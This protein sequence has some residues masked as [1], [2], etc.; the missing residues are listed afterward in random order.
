MFAMPKIIATVIIWMMLYFGLHAQVLP[1]EIDRQKAA[2]SVASNDTARLNILVQLS[3]G[4]RFSNI[5]SALHYTEQAIKIAKK[6]NS[7]S[8]QAQMLSLKG[9]TLLESGRLP[10]S[11]QYQFEALN[12]GEEIKDTSA[13]AF[14]LNRIGNVYMELG[15][16]AKANDYYFLSESQFRSIRDT[17][18]MHNELSNIGNI[19]ALMNKPDSALYYQHIVY[20][21]SKITDDRNK[22]TRAEIMFRMGNAYQLNNDYSKA[23]SF[24]KQGIV[25][26]TIDNDLRNLS[27]TNLSIADL[28]LKLKNQD[29]AMKYARLALDAAQIITFR[30][31]IREAYLRISEMYK[32]NDEYAKAY[33]FLVAADVERDSLTGTDRL[34]ELQQIILQDQER[35]RLERT[36]QIAEKNNRKQMLLLAGAFVFIVLASILYYN[37]RQKQAANKVL[38]QS[39]TKLKATQAQLIQSEKM[40]SLGELTTGIAHEIQNPLNFVNNFSEINAELMSELVDEVDKGNTAEVKSIAAD[41]KQNLDKINHHGKRADAIVKGMLEHSRKSEGKKEPTDLNALSDEF[42]RLS[43]HGLRAKEKSFKADFHTDFDSNLPKAEV[44][45][46]DIG[47]VLLNLINNAFYAVNE[48]SKSEHTPS[49]YQ[50]T[51]KVSTAQFPPHE[52][53][54]AYIELIV[55]DNGPGIPDSIKDKIFQP[56]F[57]T[58][59]TGQGTGLGLSLSYDI[60]KAHGGELR[61]ESKEGEGTLFSIQLPLKP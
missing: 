16:Y 60:V 58:K 9:A 18:M 14:A 29:S 32:Q 5:D 46:Q 52:G 20:N 31:G 22:Y 37:N 2:L 10:E 26:A 4:Y 61:V 25:E 44:I 11:L 45:P 38:E 54:V 33:T 34:R 13:T 19:Y 47:R 6:I 15:D 53:E 50:P 27:M 39:L 3:Y 59:P 40:A 42:L 7:L 41:I 57:T 24:Y 8:Q 30:K 55:S 28:Y 43:Y 35:Q 17:G 36:Q 1:Q 21:A 49:T 48:K 12:I 56:F 23:L 51:V